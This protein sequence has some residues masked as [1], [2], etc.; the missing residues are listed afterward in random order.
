MPGRAGKPWGPGRRETLSSFVQDA[1]HRS[2][3]SRKSQTDTK[4]SFV[5]PTPP[6]R[7]GLPLVHGG[8]QSCPSQ[9]QAGLRKFWSVGNFMISQLKH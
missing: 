2:S 7:H 3:V 9:A 5:M 1:A 6:D 8:G 4:T